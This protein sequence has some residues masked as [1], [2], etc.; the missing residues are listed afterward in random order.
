MRRARLLALCLGLLPM[1]LPGQDWSWRLP[2]LDGRRFVA[3][4]QQPGP[5]LVNFWGVDCPPCI[6]EL[7]RLQAFADAHPHWQ[8]LLVSTDSPREAA[9][10][11]ARLDI[12]L[13]AL[14]GGA[15]MPA[16]MRRAGN[17]QG[18]LPFSV[19]LPAPGQPICARHLGEL[20]PADLQQ[21]REACQH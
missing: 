1:Q 17:P 2:S 14:R 5:L 20:R 13:P 8:V 19:A 6:A 9:A 7:P 12:R 11:L 4:D 21:F 15:G 18:V 3:S 16:L 10:M